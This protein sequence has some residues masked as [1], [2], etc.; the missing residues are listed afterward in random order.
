MQGH[1]NIIALRLRGLKPS[2]TVSLNDYPVHQ[3]LL[4]WDYEE[5][6]INPIVCTHGD[7][8]ASLD[9]RF[10]VGLPVAIGGDDPNRVR[11]IGQMARKA[12]AEMVSCISGDKA[13]IWFK[14][15]KQWRIF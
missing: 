11:L 8:I 13:A 12:G 15:E 10:L 9:L 3:H 7:S 5:D 14:G 4:R 1:T 6:G 2:G